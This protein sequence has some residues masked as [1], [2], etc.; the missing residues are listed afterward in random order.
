MAKLNLRPDAAGYTYTPGSEVVEVQLEG[1]RAYRRK[2]KEK[3]TARVTATWV[4]DATQYAYFWAF[5]RQSTSRGA[6]TF[7]IALVLE[8]QGLVE[9]T[10]AFVGGIPT[11][12]AIQ[13]ETYT[14]S[15][16]LEVTL[17]TPDT[18]ADTA[19]INLYG[20]YGDDTGAWINRLEV[21]M[22]VDIT[23]LS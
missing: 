16:E 20:I 12:D 3:S 5:Y 11:T 6:E 10:A 8:D 13:G 14:V 1:G 19:L 2:T 17:P 15:C 7:T 4:L 18:D 22:N 23:V 21:L 9:A